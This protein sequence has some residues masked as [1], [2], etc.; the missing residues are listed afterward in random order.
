MLLLT[1]VTSAVLFAACGENNVDDKGSTEL[2]VT[3]ETTELAID[4]NGGTYSIGYTIENGINGIDIVAEDDVA[5]IDNFRTEDGRLYFDCN[6]N[7]TDKSRNASIAVRYPNYSTQFIKVV[8]SASDALTFEMEIC[9][10]KTTSCSSKLYPSDKETP[11]IVF[12]A[13]KDYILG[14][15]ITNE[16]ELF[17][18]DYKT[19]TKWAEDNG[20]SNLQQFMKQHEIYYTGDSYIGWTGMVPDKEYVIYAYAIEFSEDGQDYELAS[21]VTHEIVILPTQI[22]ADIE[23]DVD[24][25]VDGP[26][27]TYNFEPINWDGKY[28]IDI[29][30]EG[31]YMYVAEGETPNDAYCKQVANNWISMVTIYMQSGYSA[32]QLIDIMCLQG[33][34][35][36]SEVRNSDTKYC[37]VFYGVE[38]VDG[39]PQVTTKP[40]IAHFRTEKVEASD[41]QINIKVENCYVRVADVEITPSNNDESYVATFLRK[42]D[43]PYADGQ[44]IIEWLL[45]F[46]LSGN[47]YRGPIKSN[48]SGLEP[49]TEYIALAFGYYGGVVTTELF[50]YEF[51]TDPEGVCENSV[52]GVNVTAPYS[53]VE[54]EAAMPDTFYNYG[55]FESMGWYA[56]CAEIET[57]KQEGNVFMNIYKVSDLVPSDTDW[58]KADVCSY[59]SDRSCL[60]VGVNDE[61]YVMCA[62]AMDYKGNYSE[63]WMSEPFS[64]A[65]TSETK[66]D[67]NEFLDKLGLESEAQRAGAKSANNVDISFKALK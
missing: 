33:P 42:S 14:A 56:M 35:S 53:L 59:V 26:K 34:D 63:M 38:M 39:L 37:M 21:P 48:I 54:L 1:L 55:M 40:Y 16:Q 47:T 22:F 24:I 8:Q 2:S 44:Q 5:W 27:A 10:I 25:T 36:Y 17:N 28:Y 15:N 67:I 46:D 65:L 13:E 3:L 43:V 18:D 58:I 57:E 6:R 51:K 64:F 61:L 11:Y 41:M 32:E 20:A 30:A 7:F 29:Y 12:M 62:V 52:V 66:R 31:D 49:D 45:S 4:G 19:F 50:S 9:D 23:F 60:F